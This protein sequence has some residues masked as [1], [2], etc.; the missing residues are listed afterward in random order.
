MFPFGLALRCCEGKSVRVGWHRGYDRMVSSCPLPKVLAFRCRPMA[1]RRPNLEGTSSK[2]DGG[3]V[4]R[5][6]VKK[7]LVAADEYAMTF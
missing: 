4:E 5:N 7:V 2:S 1:E 6:F 3:L